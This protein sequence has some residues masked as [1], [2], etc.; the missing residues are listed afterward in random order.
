MDLSDLEA[1][2]ER[3]ERRTRTVI[4]KAEKS[5]F[6]L[7]PTDNLE[8]FRHQYELIY[9]RQDNKM[10]VASDLVQRFV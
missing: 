5:G 3:V 10:P 1:L 7:R 6:Q 4:R 9:T 2:W 8:L